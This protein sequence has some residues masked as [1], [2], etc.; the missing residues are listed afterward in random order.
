MTPLPIVPR[1]ASSWIGRT[2]AVGCGF[3]CLGDRIRAADTNQ[4]A[5]E[6][7]IPKSVFVSDGAVGRDP[8][9]P[10]S[11][12][13]QPK[14]VDEGKGTQI[15]EDFSRMLRLTGIAGGTKPIATINNLTFEAG[16]EQEVKVDNRR[17]KIRVQ[18][19]RE[20]SVLVRI[21]GQPALVELKLRD[22]Q[23]P[24]E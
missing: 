3:F 13:L 10:R 24:L 8:F 18:E 12:R 15:I 19:I 22:F 1:L 11:M 20:K 2:L 4:V 6:L 23:L 21:E 9:F 17:V 5:S 16:E 14:K 7:V